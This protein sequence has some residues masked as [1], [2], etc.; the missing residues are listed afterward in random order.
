MSY[1]LRSEADII[2]QEKLD[3]YNSCLAIW[4]ESRKGGSL[5]E[6]A[7]KNQVGA[8]RE[9]LGRNAC[10]R[11]LIV[12]AQSVKNPDTAALKGYDAGKKISG[13]ER[14]RLAQTGYA[15]LEVPIRP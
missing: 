9:K 1:S 7:L 6:Q 13:I 3:R 12:D 10:S 2:R 11:L 8:A 4:S 5:L 14:C 15:F